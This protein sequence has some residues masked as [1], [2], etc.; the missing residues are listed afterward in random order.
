[1]RHILN[2]ENS[3][4]TLIA[5]GGNTTITVAAD[6]I[7]NPDET[8]HN[9]EDNALFARIKVLA[10]HAQL[11]TSIVI[12]CDAINA[13]QTRMNEQREAQ[14]KAAAEKQAEETRIARQF[15]AEKIH[16]GWSTCP[17]EPAIVTQTADWAWSVYKQRESLREKMAN[18]LDSP[19]KLK[20]ALKRAEKN[21]SKI[22]VQTR[23]NKLIADAISKLPRNPAQP[24]EGRGNV[25]V[26]FGG[27]NSELSRLIWSALPSTHCYLSKYGRVARYIS[28]EADAVVSKIRTKLAKLAA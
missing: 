8:A 19:A 12:T 11:D 26:D 7:S 22:K 17:L 14:E 2:T 23:I 9:Y 6:L 27:L 21:A 18:L 20:A 28:P 4:A 10:E 5:R 25:R 13:A 24:V 16:R 15:L 1:M 3:T